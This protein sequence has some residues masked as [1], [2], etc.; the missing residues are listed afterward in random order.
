MMARS[1]SSRSIFSLVSV[2]LIAKEPSPVQEDSKGSDKAASETDGDED[3]EEPE[4]V[5]GS[6]SKKG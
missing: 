4:P 1:P 3:D 5:K 6:R 2:D